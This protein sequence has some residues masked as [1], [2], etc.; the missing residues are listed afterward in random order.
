MV[1]KNRN[2]KQETSW[3]DVRRAALDDAA[4]RILVD[5]TASDSLVADARAHLTS[6]VEDALVT[7]ASYLPRL[8][9]A[10]LQ[11]LRADLTGIPTTTTAPAPTAP[12][13]TAPVAEPEDQDSDDDKQVATTTPKP[14]KQAARPVPF[15]G[16]PPKIKPLDSAEDVAWLRRSEVDRLRR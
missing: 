6:N 2:K 3:S 9:V 4:R 1:R 5:P 13:T 10:T 8:S 15:Y 7:A 11:A 12:T 16:T 14:K